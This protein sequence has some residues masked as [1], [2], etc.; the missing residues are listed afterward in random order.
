MFRKA[1][2]RFSAAKET[3]LYEKLGGKPAIALAVDKFY[4]KMMADPLTNTFFKGVDMA[5]QREKQTKFLTVLTG[6][7]NDYTWR[8]MKAGHAG[9]GIKDVHFDR[10]LL[11]LIT[12]LKELG[13]AENLV[14][15]VGGAF[16]SFRKQV[17]E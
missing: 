10:T 8:D 14:K 4:I 17:V 13:V 9:L 12:V 15:D 5:R 6:G 3:T 2:Y 7:P 16:E 1:L 11:H